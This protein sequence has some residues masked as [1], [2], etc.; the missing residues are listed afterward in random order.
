M[1]TIKKLNNFQ[2]SFFDETLQKSDTGG[3]D[4][5][6]DSLVDTVKS[7]FGEN[8]GAMAETV[9]GYVKGLFD[10]SD[11]EEPPSNLELG[12]TTIG[13]QAANRAGYN[14]DSGDAKSANNGPA[15]VN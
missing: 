11:N 2:N 1:S 12:A 8:L 10:T 9:I 4:E 15:G 3:A 13:Q 5:F 14:P 6:Y 7:I